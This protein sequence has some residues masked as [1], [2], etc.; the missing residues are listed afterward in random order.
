MRTY[1]PDRFDAEGNRLIVTFFPEL[2]PS[3][4]AELKA[5]GLLRRF[6]E[7]DTVSAAH[8][9]HDDGVRHEGVRYLKLIDRERDK[10]DY[11]EWLIEADD[12]PYWR[13]TL[14]THA[15]DGLPPDRIMDACNSCFV[16]DYL[17]SQIG[18]AEGDLQPRPE[19]PVE[20]HTHPGRLSVLWQALKR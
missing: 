8:R 4:V 11:D 3:R 12:K 2:F 10:H 18:V 16:W 9:V 5:S 14:R 15:K 6:V 17:S 20:E 7:D 19:P 1:D 13:I